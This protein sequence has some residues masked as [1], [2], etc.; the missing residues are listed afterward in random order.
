VSDELRLQGYH[1]VSLDIDPRHEPTWV[2]DV[3]EWDYRKYCQP[4]DFDLVWAS[5]PCTEFSQA[6]TTGVRN[7]EYADAVVQK[8]L[9]ILRF[10]APARWYL[11]NPRH[12]L[13]PTRTYMQGLPFVDVNY[14]QFVDW[15]YQKPTR[16]WGTSDLLRLP[17]R[18][19]DPHTCPFVVE[20]PDG[21]RGHWGHL[22]ATHMTATPQEKGRVPAGLI[23][24]LLGVPEPEEFQR[25]VQV[26]SSVMVGPVPDST[27]PPLD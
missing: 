24:Y 1:V 16:I 9:E 23:R 27:I 3:L 18:K 19:C 26:L 4:G 8:T 7:L 10:L 15:G 17:S 2:C 11:E 25:I 12:G 14:C 22:G 5:P 20:R 6:K 13:L 21:T